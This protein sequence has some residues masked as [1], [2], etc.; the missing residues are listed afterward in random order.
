MYNYIK[1]EKSE[2]TAKEIKAI[3][4]R[5]LKNGKTTGWDVDPA[6]GAIIVYAISGICFEGQYYSMR[7]GEPISISKEN[8]IKDIRG[9]MRKPHRHDPLQATGTGNIVYRSNKCQLEFLLQLRSDVN[10]YGLLGGGLELGD[11]YLQCAVKELMQ[12]AALLV[13]EK[14]LKLKD[15]YAG[16]RH[17]TKYASGDLVFHTVIVYACDYEKCTELGTVLDSETK[18]LTWI[19]KQKLKNML[20]MEKERFFPNNIPIL[21]DIINNFFA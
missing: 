1:K 12:E 9:N 19:S 15:V 2:M 10:Q 4:E 7:T 13:K 18:Q 11:T 3:G 6:T 14:E 5:Y 17:V 16:P 8:Y 21:W 20:E